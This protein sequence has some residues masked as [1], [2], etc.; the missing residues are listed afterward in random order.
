MSHA[1]ILGGSGFFGKSILDA[2]KRGLL[3]EHDID[4]ITIVSRHATD[5]I[6]LHPELMKQSVHLV[7]ADLLSCDSLPS[8]DLVIHAAAST[9]ASKYA[10]YP[11]EERNNILQGISNFCKISRSCLQKSKIL[12][13]SSGAVYGDYP[14]D[15]EFITEEYPM[16]AGDRIVSDKRVYTLA[17]R[18][19]ERMVQNLGADGFDVSIARCFAFVGKYLLRDQ[20]FAI[21]NFIRDGLNKKPIEVK[22]TSSVFRSYMHGDDLSQ[23]LMKIASVSSP[24]APVFNVGSD[25]AISIQDLGCKLANFFGVE[26]S[27]A[28]VNSEGINRYVPSIDKAKSQLDLKLNKN[29]DE[30]IKATINSI[31]NI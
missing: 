13:V 24:S 12:Y 1:L 31:K 21:G 16:F 29:L 14:H 23:W 27:L 20:H 2:Y 19:C 4:Q 5:L 22:T 9:D 18:E 25:E 7:N 11:E 30:S 15:I 8:A 10:L 17:K 26:V 28:A 6:N 3:R